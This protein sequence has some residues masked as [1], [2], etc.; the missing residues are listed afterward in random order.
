[1]VGT[2][3]KAR[4]GKLPVDAVDRPLAV[5]VS[6]RTE[7]EDV[8]YAPSEDRGLDRQQAPALLPGTFERGP[9]FLVSCLL[10]IFDRLNRLDVFGNILRR[11]ALFPTTCKDKVLVPAIGFEA[12]VD[13]VW[14]GEIGK[15]LPPATF[16]VD[17]RDDRVLVAVADAFGRI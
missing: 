15:G 6:V 9:L 16:V 17:D 14:G 5:G 12:V 4:P 2:T 3:F 13:I 8:L 1:M 10:G 7:S 11:Q